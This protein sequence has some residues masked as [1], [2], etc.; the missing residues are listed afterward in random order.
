[1]LIDF[2]SAATSATTR[3]RPGLPL[4]VAD[5]CNPIANL[6]HLALNRK[7]ESEGSA[8]PLLALHVDRTPVFRHDLVH[9]AQAQPRS[10]PRLLRREE[11]VV[12]LV[13]H[14]LADPAAG[15]RDLSD[16]V[17]ALDAGGQGEM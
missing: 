14:R 10:L 1:M 16:H 2:R 9:D 11:R 5:V 8:F 6:L 17:L 12:D 13:Q 4:P 7:S 3:I 15:V